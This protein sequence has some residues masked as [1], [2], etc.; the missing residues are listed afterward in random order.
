MSDAKKKKAKIFF[1]S[2]EQENIQIN[3]MP[4]F[5]R[6]TVKTENYFLYVIRS[7]NIY[8]KTSE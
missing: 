2:Q 3:G 1:S 5:F 8:Q 4:T 6:S 7:Q